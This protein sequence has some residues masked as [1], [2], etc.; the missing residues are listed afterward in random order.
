MRLRPPAREI[1]PAE[2]FELVTFDVDRQ[3][4]ERRRRPGFD[5]GCRRASCTGTSMT[6]SGSR[7]RRH[8]IAIERRQCAGDV[9]SA[10][11]GRRSAAT[12]RRPRTPW[13]SASRRSSSARSGCGSTRTPVQP[14]CS[15]C[16]VC[17]SCRGRL[18]P[19]STKKPDRAPPKNVPHELLLA[20]LGHGHV[21]PFSARSRALTRL[22]RARSADDPGG[23]E[24]GHEIDQD[25]FAAVALRP[26]RGPRPPRAG[27]RRP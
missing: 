26:P 20:S 18:A 19:T 3:K 10:S 27:S 25:H 21:Q 5:R 9:E 2:H 8:P 16:Q 15:R 24:A 7:A 12:S 14:S 22:R 13:R 1:E 17:D 11:A 6:R 4:I 23:A